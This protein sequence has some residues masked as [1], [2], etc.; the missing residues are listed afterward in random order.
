MSRLEEILAPYEV[1]GELGRGKAFDRSYLR[2]ALATASRQSAIAF[3]LAVTAQVGVFLLATWFAVKNATNPRVLGLILFGGC[4]GVGASCFAV[5]RL[6]KDKVA[7][8]L[9]LALVSSLDAA[10]A[11]TVLNVVLESFRGGRKSGQG[12]HKRHADG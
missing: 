10:A 12:A 9:T 2:S 5:A 6:W 8:D 3:W 1:L 11:V 4:G 7:T